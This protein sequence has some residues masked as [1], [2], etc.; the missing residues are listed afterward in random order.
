MDKDLKPCPFCGC[1]E[2][3]IEMRQMPWGAA[4]RSIDWW[5]LRCGGCIAG[6]DYPT[7]DGL[8]KNWNT[9]ATDCPAVDVDLYEL[10]QQINEHFCRFEGAGIQLS[11]SSLLRYLA[12]RNLI[13]GAMP[14]DMVLVPREP[15][16]KTIDAILDTGLVSEYSMK[17]D[18]Q[19]A[20]VLYQ[21]MT[22]G[23]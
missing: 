9:R 21:A 6:S 15:T 10:E 5:F 3:E 13:R 23:E 19:K 4:D 8:I 17:S 16:D 18:A 2:I 1:D 20:L 7:K 14:D 12:S 22:K 11:L